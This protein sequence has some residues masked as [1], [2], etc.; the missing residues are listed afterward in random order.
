MAPAKPAK[1]NRAE[2]V[3]AANLDQ[4][5]IPDPIEAEIAQLTA[6]LEELM[7]L[8]KQQNSNTSTESK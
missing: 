7:A 2:D 1:K 5:H 6:R 4:I 3:P 8:S